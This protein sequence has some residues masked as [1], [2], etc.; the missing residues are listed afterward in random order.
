MVKKKLKYRFKFVFRR[1]LL[2]VIALLAQIILFF[3]L[4]AG[5][6]IYLKYSYWVLSVLSVFVCINIINKHEK[7]GFK[8]TW[9]FIILMVPLFGGILYIVLNFW[10]NPKKLRRALFGNIANSREAFYLHGNR[11]DDLVNNYPDFESQAHYLQEYAAFP[12]TA[13]QDR[14]IFRLVNFFLRE[15]WK[16]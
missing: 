1:R 15:Y 9:I 13:T 4:I 6:G 12:C 5:T 3:F 8:M 10:S 14:N 16:I 11:L 2:V 7:A